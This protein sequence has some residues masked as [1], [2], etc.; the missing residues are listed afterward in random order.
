MGQHKIKILVAIILLGLIATPAAAVS[1]TESSDPSGTLQAGDNTI[2]ITTTYKLTPDTPG[3]ISVEL[4]A[5]MSLK[6]KEF[7]FYIPKAAETTAVDGVRRTVA[8]QEYRSNYTEFTWDGNTRNPSITFTINV[9]RTKQQNTADASSAKQYITVDAGEWAIAE[10]PTTFYSGLASEDFEITEQSEVAGEGVVADRFVFLGDHETRTRQANGQE[11]RLVIPA[12]ATLAEPPEAILDNVGYASKQLEVGAKD[13]SVLM[14]AAPTTD[15]IQWERGGTAGEAIFWARDTGRL[16]DP[17]NVWIH[18][19][20][21]T[22]QAFD[23]TTDFEWF[24]EGSAHYYAALYTL[25]QEQIGFT[26]YKEYL[27]SEARATANAVLINT[28]DGSDAQYG[29]GGLVAARTDQ[30]IRMVTDGSGSL[31]E[32]FRQMNDETGPVSNADFIRYV[33]LYSNPE[34]E[35]DVKA[36]TTSSETMTMWDES[37]HTNAFGDKPY[38][39]ENP[40]DQSSENTNTALVWLLL[41][42]ALAGAISLL[43]GVVYVIYWLYKRIFVSSSD[44]ENS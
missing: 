11:F 2:P 41:L 16:D 23:R 37:G 8:A 6:I 10:T 20:V 24:G 14:I 3:S 29:K 35:A 38:Q 36:A 26:Q 34:L 9:N 1:D 33:G 27:S 39:S 5:D 12:A 30:R 32:I 42:L 13:D 21:H 19:Y 17:R 40:S 4:S 28:K 15:D 43:V 18:E 7:E 22:R 31:T 44:E 25:Q